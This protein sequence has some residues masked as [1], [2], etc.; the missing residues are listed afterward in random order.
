M[1]LSDLPPTHQIIIYLYRLR[2]FILREGLDARLPYSDL[3]ISIST[4][5]RILEEE[6]G[7]DVW[8]IW[9]E[10]DIMDHLPS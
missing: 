10:F 3:H 7:L 6:E 5:L 4:A 1:Q 9:W 8:R 2:E